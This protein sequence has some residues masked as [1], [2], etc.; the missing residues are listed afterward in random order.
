MGG[1]VAWCKR[2]KRG[3]GPASPASHPSSAWSE[4]GSLIWG[5]PMALPAPRAVSLETDTLLTPSWS[6][7]SLLPCPSPAPPTAAAHPRGPEATAR[8]AVVPRGH[9]AGGGERAADTVRGLPGAGE[10]GQA[11]VRAV[12]AVGGPAPALHHPVGRRE[13]A[14]PTLGHQ[15][16][17]GASLQSGPGHRAPQF[18]QPNRFKPSV[19]VLPKEAGV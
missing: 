2:E 5:A 1:G 4:S 19:R 15:G 9:P 8:A 13:C 3:A 6:P 16:G 14:R 18:L 17:R 11:G 12:R 10:P 7:P